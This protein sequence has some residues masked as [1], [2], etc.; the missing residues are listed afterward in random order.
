MTYTFRC[1]DDGSGTTVGTI[2]HFDSVTI[3]VDPGWNSEKVSYTDSVKYWSNIIPD[4]DII[5][6]SQPTL[7]CLGAYTLLYYNFLSHFISRIEVYSTLPVSN[8]GRISTIDFYTSKGIV[9]PFD[10][11]QLDLEDIENSFDFITTLKYSQ[12]VDWRSKYDGL[13]F[14]AYSAGGAPGGSIWCISTYVEKL[15][16][17]RH[18]NHTRDSILNSASFLDSSGKPLSTLLRPSAIITT[19]NKFGSSTPYRRRSKIFLDSI[20]NGLNSNSSV[21]IPTE[22]GGNFLNLFVLVHDYLYETYRNS[23]SITF[24]ILL[25]S[26]ARGRILT[27]AKSMLEWLSASLL[28][29]WELR[30]NRSP[31][32]LGD[33]FHVISPEEIS[34]YPGS[35]I[36]FVSQVDTLIDDIISRLSS[37]E[38]MSVILTAK[39]LEENNVISKMYENFERKEGTGD[40][41]TVS[42]TTSMTMQAVKLE[43]LKKKAQKDYIT[44][45]DERRKDFKEKEEKLKIEL[46][47][48]SK[49]ANEFTSNDTK[50]KKLI[51]DSQNQAISNSLDINSDDEEDEDVDDNFSRI[52]NGKGS[53]VAQFKKVE[54]PIDLHLT[55]TSKHKMFPFKPRLEKKDDYGTVIDFSILIPKEQQQQEDLLKKRESSDEYNPNASNKRS[56]REGIINEE[57]KS[58]TK[59]NFDNIEYLN[60]QN[61]PSKRTLVPKEVIV[62]CH[63][64]YVN[65]DGMVDQRSASVIIP[66]LKPRKV[67]LLASNGPENKTP[68]KVFKKKNIEIVYSKLNT[69]L[70]LDTTI[71]AL[72]ISIDVELDQLLKWQKIGDDHTVAHVIGRLVKEMPQLAGQGRTTSRSKLV[73]KPITKS[74]KIHSSGTLSIGDVRL[75]E[76]KRKLTEQNHVA[77]FKGEGMLVID[78]EVAVRKINESET[79]IDGTPTE[80]FDIV[81]KAVTDMLAKI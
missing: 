72:D 10:T 34:K 36:I 32:E 27:Y 14:I 77:E 8:L 71:K 59:E 30:D 13:S 38:K 58:K 28:K 40:G 5:I 39:P 33:K 54:I 52:L 46:I 15:I 4:V 74:N 22:I 20:K 63:V 44:M 43:P 78:G 47:Q 51:G 48:A 25:V 53:K 62:N 17:A 81:K 35:K 41:S 55:E 6:L 50:L 49:M 45:I 19:F 70:V 66:S 68:E 60:A 64:T 29:T 23:K 42:F 65:L 75:A 67:I 73:L 7:E 2:I 26:Y 12:I 21:I 76:L 24:P 57:N 79:I 80:T 31:F 9:G 37:V 3:L 18:W 56:H 11:N 69:D 16:Y 61:K 1:C